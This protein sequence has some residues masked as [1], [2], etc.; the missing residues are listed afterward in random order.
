MSAESCDPCLRR[1]RL[2]A[3]LAP[4]ITG[5]LGRRGGRVPGLLALSDADLIAAAGGKG[6]RAA[7]ERLARFDVA[8]ERAALRSAGAFAVCRHSTAYP[9]QLLEMADPP[10]ALFCVGRRAALDAV[11]D[12]PVVALVGTRRPS[13]YG[14]EVAYA[15]GRGLGAAGVT[16]VSGLALGIDATAH[17]GCLDGSGTPVAVLACGPERAYPRRHRR[18]H[19]GVTQRGLVVS[20]L[21]PGTDAQR[22]SFP[23]R[24][25]IMAGLARMTLVVEAADPS[26]SLI[27]AEFAREL[28]RVVAAV[29]GRI[30]ARMAAGTNGLLR[31]GAVPVTGTEDALDELY[32]V[33]V[34]PASAPGGLRAPPED[35]ALRAVLD[36]VEG[37]SGVDEIV[38]STRAS[39][40]EVRAALGRLEAGGHVVRG[41]LGGWERAAG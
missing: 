18:L 19:A 1:S 26:G 5:L 20:E 31:D 4:R 40:A 23:A 29:P 33:G 3:D 22:W 17:R 34:R 11:R 35:P 41:A 8:A 14:N 25:R 27:T 39:A 38:R 15:L 2:V 32:G 6:R 12:G 10:A 9:P 16:V 30:T 7:R 36:A 28:G 37:G 21:P 24:N 13:P